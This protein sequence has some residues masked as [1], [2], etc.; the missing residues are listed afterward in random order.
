MEE[1]TGP[2]RVRRSCLEHDHYI[3]ILPL[4]AWNDNAKKSP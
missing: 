3:Y 1:C 4:L 2:N